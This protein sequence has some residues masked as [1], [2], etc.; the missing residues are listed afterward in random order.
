WTFELRPGATFHDG[1]PVTVDDIVASLERAKNHPGSRV[2]GYLVA[3]DSVRAVDA[4]HVE[5]RTIRPYPILLNKL[6]FVAIVPA[7]A[8]ERIERP[9]GSGPYRLQAINLP[10]RFRLTALDDAATTIEV[11]DF[12]VLPSAE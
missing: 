9:I 12:L 11:A 6:S 5:I 2:S 1:R 3:V 4:E 8:P 7:D 10:G